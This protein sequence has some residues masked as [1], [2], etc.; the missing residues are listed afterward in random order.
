MVMVILMISVVSMVMAQG[1]SESNKVSSEPVEIRIFTRWSGASTNTDLMKSVID[2]LNQ[3]SDRFVFIDESINEESAY[4]TKWRTDLATGNLPSVFQ[5]RGIN[6]N[7]AL[8]KEGLVADL[9]SLFSEQS[10]WSAGFGPGQLAG[11]TYDAFGVPG[12]YAVP[13]V[14]AV[15][16]F[17]YNKSLFE[18]AGVTVPKTYAEFE[19]V[20]DKLAASG[21]IP[22]GVGGSDTWRLVHIWNGLFYKLNGVDGALAL[23]NREMDYTDPKVIRVLEEM[24]KLYERG[25]F[26]KGSDFIGNSYEVEKSLL[27]NEQ[28]AM[29]FNGTWLIGELQDSNIADEIGVF[30]LPGFTEYP[31]WA[32]HG[33]EYPNH[34]M[35]NGQ[36]N[37][38]EKEGAYEFIRA[39]TSKATMTS[40]AQRGGIPA[41][42]DVDLSTLDDQIFIETIESTRDWTAAGIDVHAYDS[43]TEIGARIG[44]A[45]TGLFLGRTPTEVATELQKIAES[46]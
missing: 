7:V 3:S 25:A 15:E 10:A 18:K 29:V 36:L 16:V 21:V 23:A 31:Q 30:A 5:D 45:L 43:N 34:L 12:I 13:V 6:E 2:E 42:A 11:V 28:A 32:G 40:L 8:A 24:V 4:M 44:A 26:G 9:S 17:F 39:F 35:V 38:L 14:R 27:F 1:A 22:W 41:R 19:Q 20:I 46:K 37:D 33:V